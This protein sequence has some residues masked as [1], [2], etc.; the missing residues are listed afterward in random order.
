ME[1]NKIVFYSEMRTNFYLTENQI[2]YK[3]DVY[4]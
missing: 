1:N 2:K 3:I 4:F